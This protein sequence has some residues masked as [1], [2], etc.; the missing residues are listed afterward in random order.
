MRDVII[1]GGGLAGLTSAIHLSRAGL[2]VTVVEKHPYPR[3]KVCGEYISNEVLPYLQWL[4]A[5]PAVLQP[6][7]INRVSIS[8]ITGKMVETI[9]PMGGFGISRYT[10]DQFLMQQAVNNG[11]ELLEDTVTDILFEDN[12]FNVSTA[13]NGLLKARFVLGAYG[14]RAILDQQLKRSFLQERSPWL[15]VKGHYKGGFPDGLVALHNF[16]GGYCGVS[17][18]ENDIINIC[19]LVNYNTFKQYKNIDTHRE[20][21]LYRNKHLKEV[22]ENSEPIFD[23]PLT[24]S[25]VSFAAKEKVDQ[26]ILMTGDTAGLIHPLCGN[27]MAMAIHSAKIASEEV[28]DFFTTNSPSRNTLENNYI[29]NWNNAFGKRIAAGKLLSA[30][31][32]KHRLSTAIMKG[33]VLFPMLLPVIIRQTHGKELNVTD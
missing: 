32:R 28:L 29:K 31:F 19:Y 33:L 18:V 6:A 7:Q 30:L 23:R 2:H 24:I 1:A 12:S 3:H 5:D 21:V 16:S 9:L 15:A 10:F 14:K 4:G 11:C 22:F 25:Q 8:A 20:Q 13:E 26:H 27:G 17:K